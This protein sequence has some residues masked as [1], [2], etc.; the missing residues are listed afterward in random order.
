MLVF[1]ENVN[2]PSQV[3]PD[4][5][6]LLYLKPQ[7]SQG[8]NVYL[9]PMSGERTPKGL[10]ESPFA[11]VEPQFSPNM[12]W[13]AYA[14]SETG[15]NEVYVQPF[16]ATG[17]RWQ[18]SNSGGRQPLWRSD[19]KELYFVADDA[20]FYVVTV[21]EPSKSFD[22]GK[23]EFLFDMPANVFNSLKS[24]IPSRDGSRFLVNMNGAPL[25]VPIS[26]VYNWRPGAEK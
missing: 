15:R 17:E 7:P 19:G 8:M 13:L 14:S 9:L 18:V 25:A 12:R 21:T 6:W 20:K 3:S 23:P 11:E 1:K 16:P 22:Y 26:V 24:Y 2:G 10:V 5:K 4:G